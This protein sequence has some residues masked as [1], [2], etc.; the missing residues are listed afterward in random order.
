MAV[1]DSTI[2]HVD[3]LFLFDFCSLIICF[4]FYRAKLQKKIQIHKYFLFFFLLFAQ[5]QNFS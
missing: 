2:A 5:M 1:I 4:V 3:V